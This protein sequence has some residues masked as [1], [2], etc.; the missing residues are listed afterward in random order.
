[1]DEK[2]QSDC[3]QWINQRKWA[4]AREDCRCHVSRVFKA[5]IQ[6]SLATPCFHC[7]AVWGKPQPSLQ[8]T[9]HYQS[10]P[11]F[12]GDVLSP[13][14][15][16]AWLQGPS[17]LSPFQGRYTAA[18]GHHVL[19]CP[20]VWSKPQCPHCRQSSCNPPDF[21]WMSSSSPCSAAAAMSRSCFL[22]S[23]VPGSVDS[24]AWR[25][26]FPHCPAVWSE[27]GC[28]DCSQPADSRSQCHLPLRRPL[29]SR[30]PASMPHSRILSAWVPGPVYSAAGRYHVLYCP[31]VW[32]QFPRPPIKHNLHYQPA[33]IIFSRDKVL[34]VPGPMPP[35][36][37]A[38][39]LHPVLRVSG[40]YTVQPG[41]TMFLLP[42]GLG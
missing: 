7:P 40:R 6:C 35:P 23:W 30:I 25:H 2:I 9:P 12:P 1:M 39:F 32:G 11:D 24:A 29:C 36:P 21:P 5:G 26:H 20:A 15:N 37:P 10:R 42:S 18:W 22:S 27:L 3:C 28:F 31:A 14:C 13:R 38:E 41:D 4:P 19:H 16:T 34:C 33:A 17:L 8:L